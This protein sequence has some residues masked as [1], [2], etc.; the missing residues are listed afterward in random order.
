MAGTV[1]RRPRH[2]GAGASLLIETLAKGE[3]SFSRLTCAESLA[4]PL[5]VL[6]RIPVAA[7][8]AGCVT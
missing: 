2:P 4:L 6:S 8:A 1:G 3:L 7:A 5:C